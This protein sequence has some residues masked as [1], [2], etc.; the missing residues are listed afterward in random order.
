LYILL[1]II[2]V[3]VNMLCYFSQVYSIFI[4]F[5]FFSVM[6]PYMVNKHAS[7]MVDDEKDID[8]GHN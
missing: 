6:L 7:Y 1:A 3:N 2:N 5:Q 8:N 4:F